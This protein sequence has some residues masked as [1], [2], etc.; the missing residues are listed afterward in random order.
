MALGQGY[1]WP[2]KTNTFPVFEKQSLW[3]GPSG[4]KNIPTAEVGDQGFALVFG[5]GVVKP[6]T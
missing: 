4:K 2:P 1:T 5:W 6:Q 3:G